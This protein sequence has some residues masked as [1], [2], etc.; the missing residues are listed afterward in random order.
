M[1]I[2]SPSERPEKAPA[3]PPVSAPPAP[4]PSSPAPA[5]P[6][7][8]PPRVEPAAGALP[9]LVAAR[10]EALPGWH[11]DNL[12][13]A[14]PAFVASCMALKSRPD[15]QPAC[16]AAAEVSSH[17]TP[18]LRLFFETHFLPWSVRNADGSDQGLVTGYY[19]PLLDGSRT[20]SAKYRYPVYGVPDDLVTVEIAEL[21][22]G[23]KGQRVRGRLEGRR[24]VPYYTRAQIESGQAP[25]QGREL[26]WVDDPVELFFLH[27]QGSGRIRLESGETVRVGYADHNG[28]PYRSIGRVLVERGELPPDKASM[29]GIQAWARLHPEKLPKLLAENPAY[30]FFRELP[31]GLP[32][33]VGSLGVALSA[34]RSI[35]VDPASVPLGAPVY[36]A[37]TWPNS[38]EPLNRLTLAQDTGTAIKG[39][40]RADFFWGFGAEAAA[41]AGRMRQNGRLWVLLPKGMNPPAKN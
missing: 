1:A 5:Q 26:L 21:F 35:A 33:P 24:V 9:N 29:Q 8:E 7:I 4:P 10:W 2:P 41:L 38:A 16:R 23:L 18:T 39:G 27:V 28:H 3:T 20:R 6:A 31:D 32:G 37:T 17:D 22:P 11:A 15:W 14:W 34:R 12:R 25:L 36:L 19:E 30:V 40:V 13:E